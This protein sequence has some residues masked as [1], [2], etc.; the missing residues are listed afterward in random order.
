[1]VGA[2]VRVDIPIDL[3]PEEFVEELEKAVEEAVVL[4]KL[5]SRLG[6]TDPREVEELIE[7]V[8][9]GIRE[10]VRRLLDE[11]RG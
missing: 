7:E 9:R 4:Y 1:M 5:R 6:T 8:R 10:R 3:P 11:A 2:R